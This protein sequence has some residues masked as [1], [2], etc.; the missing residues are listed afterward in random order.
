MLMI[1]LY[2]IHLFEGGGTLGVAFFFVLSGF[3]L[4]IGYKERI[5]EGTF[6]YHAF[7]KRRIVKMVPLHWLM[8]VAAAILHF[9]TFFETLPQLLANLLLVQSWI[10]KEEFYLSFNSVSWYLSDTLFLVGIFPFLIRYVM[11]VSWLCQYIVAFIV[12]SLYVALLVFLPVDFY[13]PILYISPLVR[14]MD[15]VVGIYLAFLIIGFI[16]SSHPHLRRFVNNNYFITVLILLII[17]VLLIFLS[18]ILD[19]PHKKISVFYWPFISLLIA[20]VAIMGLLGNGGGKRGLIYWFGE[21][22]F[23]F[24]MTHQIVIRYSSAFFFFF[25]PSLN[26]W[27]HYVLFFFISVSVAYF[28]DRFF[29]KPISNLVSRESI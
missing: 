20:Y 5:I 6:N 3:S 7:L 28:L 24:F 4:T 18:Q 14:M 21:I 12:F 9:R 26:M 2:H 29:V 19:F 8:L 1:F 17:I 27:I 16:D 25:F 22:S 11:K 23:T 15:F 10:P 13:S